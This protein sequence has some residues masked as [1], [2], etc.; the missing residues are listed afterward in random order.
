MNRAM[1]ERCRLMGF[2]SWFCVRVMACLEA[3]TVEHSGVITT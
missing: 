1:T 2:D 3:L